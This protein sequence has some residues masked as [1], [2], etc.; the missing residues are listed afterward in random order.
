MNYLGDYQKGQS[1]YLYFNTFS[2]VGASITRATNG[3]VRVYELDN[4]TEITAGITDN[5]DLDIKTG[6]HLIKIDT[7][8]AAYTAGKDYGVMLDAAVI[9]GRTINSF[10]G[11]FSI[12]NRFDGSTPKKNTAY[13][14]NV[15]IRDSADVKAGKT[16]LTLAAQVS[17]D[18][19]AFGNIAG[20]VTEIANGIYKISATAADMNAGALVFK[21]TGSGA[22]D[23][24]AEFIT[25]P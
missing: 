8:N 6:A 2:A 5:E 9:D 4:L 23:T 7:S 3:T 25:R 21:F 16:G 10:I 18:G 15:L 24:F 22:V 11:Q 19:A 13:I 17:K 1:V 14:F 12:E 20:T